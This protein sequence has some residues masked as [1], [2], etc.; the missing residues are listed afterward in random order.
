MGIEI[1][2]T[3]FKAKCLEL[4]SRLARHEIDSISITRHGK[5]VGLITPPPTAQGALRDRLA[6][7]QGMMRGRSCPVDPAFDLTAPIA[8]GERFDPETRILP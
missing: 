8:M 6:Q 1:S 7:W 2:V 4:F 5:P 3:E